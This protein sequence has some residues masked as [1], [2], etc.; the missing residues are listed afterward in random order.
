MK[1][2]QPL[3]INVLGE[4]AINTWTN[5]T[6]HP[7]KYRN[8][9]HIATFMVV[10]GNTATADQLTE[11]FWPNRPRLR[12]P[13]HARTNDFNAS[14]PNSDRHLESL[15]GPNGWTYRLHNTRSDYHELLTLDRYIRHAPAGTDLDYYRWNI[16][17][18][19]YGVPLDGIDAPWADDTRHQLQT[20]IRRHGLTLAHNA[21]HHHAWRCALETCR[22]L[23][24]A[25]A[26]TP[27]DPEWEDL[28]QIRQR[29]AL[30]TCD[31]LDMTREGLAPDSTVTNARWP[32]NPHPLPLSREEREAA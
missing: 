26:I 20:I 24:R 1:Q 9:P 19:V 18:S 4:P 29:S 13:L 23:E 2:P 14:I 22:R 21:H 17:N 6:W 12:Q 10:H 16:L 11:T 7:W 8:T 32:T 5:T 25:Q 28:I 31:P 27:D 3:R 30:G 15:A